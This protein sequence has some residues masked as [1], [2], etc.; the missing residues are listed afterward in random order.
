[1]T[2]PNF[3]QSDHDLLVSINTTVGFLME[4]QRS[5][6][7]ENSREVTDIK[8]R[9]TAV[10]RIQDRQAGFLSGGKALWAIL[11]ALPPG[12]VAFFLGLNQR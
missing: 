9:L 10:E 5:N 6:H 2:M 12:I 8:A 7:A 3:P 1:M 11:G 4:Q